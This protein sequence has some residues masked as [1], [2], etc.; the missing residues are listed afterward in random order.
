MERNIM[1]D[2]HDEIHRGEHSLEDIARIYDVPRSW[3]DLAFDEVLEQYRLE[4][5]LE[6]AIRW[7]RLEDEVDDTI[8]WN[9]LDQNR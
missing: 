5:E 3:V 6:D 8:R 9:D 2:L 7:N 4:D 1:L